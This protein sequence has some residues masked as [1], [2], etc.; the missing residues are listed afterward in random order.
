[1]GLRRNLAAYGT[2]DC[3]DA[4]FSEEQ[5]A[6]I[7]ADDGAFEAPA[8]TASV[9]KGRK[10]DLLCDVSGNKSRFLDF[11]LTP[12]VGTTVTAPA[13]PTDLGCAPA[14]K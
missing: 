4:S 6:V 13:S 12:P 1:M 11:G 8:L 3:Q 7:L 14:S 5:L 10:R 2:G 9:S